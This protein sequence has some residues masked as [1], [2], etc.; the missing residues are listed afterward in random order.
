MANN[1]ENIVYFSISIKC[2][3]VVSVGKNRP[4]LIPRVDQMEIAF[5]KDYCDGI[6]KAVAEERIESMLKA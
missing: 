3:V 6:A 4:K 5:V 2:N 1:A